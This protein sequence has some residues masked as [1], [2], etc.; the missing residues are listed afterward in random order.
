MPSDHRKSNNRDNLLQLT[1]NQLEDL[2]HK[3]VQEATK[4]LQSEIIDLKTEIAQLRESQEFL[5]GQQHSLN[6]NCNILFTLIWKLAE[7]CNYVLIVEW[8]DTAVVNLYVYLMTSLNLAWSM[9]SM[10]DKV[11]F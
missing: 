7:T 9:L 5:S 8:C 1:K 2:V 6:K 10:L 4:P 11:L 3:M